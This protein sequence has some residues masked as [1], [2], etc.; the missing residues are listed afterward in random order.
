MAAL[1]MKEVSMK[2]LPDGYMMEQLQSSPSLSLALHSPETCA[3]IILST[4]FMQIYSMSAGIL[5]WRCGF[6]F[7]GPA[8]GSV[9]STAERDPDDEQY[10]KMIA[11]QS[12][13]ALQH[14][15][16]CTGCSGIWHQI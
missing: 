12:E 10:L 15:E 5:L 3:L 2:S 11:I 4:G 1:H 9:D 7:M 16:S 13:H 6:C 8:N 14:L